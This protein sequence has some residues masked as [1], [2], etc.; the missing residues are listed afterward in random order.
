MESDDC[1]ASQALR[2]KS[3]FANPINADSS[4]QSL[5]QKNFVLPIGQIIFISPRRPV[6]VRG[7]LRD[8]HD[9]LA[10]DAMDANMSMRR[11]TSLADGEV[12]WS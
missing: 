4:V 10:R 8:R 12:V 5:V 2:Q 1:Q 6:P 3:N 11:T 9:S 7:A